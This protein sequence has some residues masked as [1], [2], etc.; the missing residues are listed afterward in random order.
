MEVC[1][2]T[3]FVRSLEFIL[4]T[5]TRIQ[6][7]GGFLFLTVKASSGHQGELFRGWDLKLWFLPVV[8]Y[9]CESWTIKKAEHRRIDAF[10]PWCLRR[11]LRVPWT[12][13]RSNQSIK[14]N[15]F[16]V[17]I[18][19]TVAKAEA[20]TLWPPDVKN[21]LIGKD[22]DAGKDWRQEEKGT[23]EDEMIGWHHR[24]SGHE[25]E[26]ALGVGDG[27]GSL[28]CCSPWG[29][30]ALDRIEQLNWTEV[31]WDSWRRKPPCS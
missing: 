28:A 20:P 12:A 8:M 11:V 31:N 5:L 18:G 16:W 6:K 15:Q 7:Q 26:Q 30:K 4:Y 25:F 17:F 10:E 21:W 23:T 13:R 9:G 14:G 3:L 24:L 2:T 19:R 22:P 29:C 27:Q 1:F